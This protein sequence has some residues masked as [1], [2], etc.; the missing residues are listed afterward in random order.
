VED[1]GWA[2]V[3]NSFIEDWHDVIAVVS[4]LDQSN[5]ELVD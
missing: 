4:P 1:H 5:V 2:I 3:V